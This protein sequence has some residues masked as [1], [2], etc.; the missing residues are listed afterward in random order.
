MFSIWSWRGSKLCSRLQMCHKCPTLVPGLVKR[1]RWKWPSP[2]GTDLYVKKTPMPL[3]SFVAYRPP[4]CFHG[5]LRLTRYRCP[6]LF[7][8]FQKG[9]D[10]DAYGL[11]PRLQ[12]QLR[13]AGID[14][15]FPVQAQCFEKVR[16]PQLSEC[17]PCVEAGGVARE[18]VHPAYVRHSSL[19]CLSRSLYVNESTLWSEH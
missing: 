2:N 17:T 9:M 8:S 16:P 7:L 6:S 15:L 1:T 11:N 12:Q 5:A 4:F 19:G 18:V 13:R 14:K 10:F 3:L